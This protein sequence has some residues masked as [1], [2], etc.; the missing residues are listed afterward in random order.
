M[1]ITSWLSN[2]AEIII[3]VSAVFTSVI[4]LAVATKALKIQRKHNCLS[5]KPIAHFSVGDYE[6]CIYVKLQ[7]YGLGPLIIENFYA[8]KNNNNYIS[9][10]ESLGDLSSKITWNA[11]TGSIDEKVISPDN[12]SILLKGSFDE[13]QDEIKKDIQKSLSK[14]KL[15]LIYKDI[16]NEMQPEKTHELTWF[17][18]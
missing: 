5:V 10:I 17:S 12:E 6:D 3:A 11:F 18:R 1:C 8:T 14:T 16:Y 9:V 7:N 2:N 4:S 15:T 13:N